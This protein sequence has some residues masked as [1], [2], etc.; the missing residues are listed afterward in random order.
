MEPVLPALANPPDEAATLR[1]EVGG[2]ACAAC[3][4]SV[5]A[6]LRAVDGVLE[7]NVSLLTSQAEARHAKRKRRS[8]LSCS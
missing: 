4:A 3:T 8:K 5:E 1:L 6:A 2:M 7:A